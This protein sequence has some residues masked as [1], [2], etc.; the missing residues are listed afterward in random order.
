[1]LA[2]QEVWDDSEAQ[3]GE[4]PTRMMTVTSAG[5]LVVNSV[6]RKKI[7]DLALTTKSGMRHYHGRR[8]T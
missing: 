6:G 1:M 4:L 3:F 7:V 8:I 5:D 2:K